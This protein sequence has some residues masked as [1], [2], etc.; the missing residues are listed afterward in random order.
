MLPMFM[1]C[2]LHHSLKSVSTKRLKNMSKTKTKS[3]YTY[4]IVDNIVCIVDQN[5]LVSVT[6]DIENVIDQICEIE[7]SV[8]KDNTMFIYQDSEG[9]WDG[10]D[11]KLDDFYFVG[12]RS[13]DEA[14][15]NLKTKFVKKFINR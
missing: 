9:N 8:N 14:I 12:G 13:R 11:P 15:E 4:T 5:G 1:R 3:S 6:N 10:Y 7:P 2:I